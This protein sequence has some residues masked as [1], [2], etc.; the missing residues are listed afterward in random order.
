MTPRR[1]T[2]LS[3]LVVLLLLGQNT[4]ADTPSG[5]IGTILL[6]L[7]HYDTAVSTATHSWRTTVTG[8]DTLMQVL[9]DT[10]ANTGDSLTGPRLEY[11][12]NVPAAGEYTVWVRGRCGD[13]EANSFHLRIGERTLTLGGCGFRLTRELGW[14]NVLDRGD[15]RVIRMAFDEPGV[16]TVHVFMREDGAEID[17]LL[18]T[19]GDETP[20]EPDRE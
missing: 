14:S 18:L 7:E 16:K 6:E 15:G 19:T 9:P 10:G 11:T 13:H 20:A 17:K 2:A 5:T 4:G 3:T 1:T 8:S 12:V